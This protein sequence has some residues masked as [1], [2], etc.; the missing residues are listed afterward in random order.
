MDNNRAEGKLKDVKGRVKRQVGEWTD[1]EKLQGEGMADQ[2]EGKV[3]NTFGRAKDK[4]EDFA[5]DVKDKFNETNR[6][7]P[8]K[9]SGDR[10]MDK[11]KRSA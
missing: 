7:E 6:P 9:D 1:N 3:Q 11:T 2:A 5:D 4:V 10:F 8:S